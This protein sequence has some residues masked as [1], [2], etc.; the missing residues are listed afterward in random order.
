MAYN[1]KL[2]EVMGKTPYFANHRKY[3]N[4][5]QRTLLSLKAEA[6]IKS[7]EEMKKIHNNISNKL[8]H[9]QNQSISYI[10]KKRNTAP[11]LKKGDKVYLHTK[12]LRIK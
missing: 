3:S 12:N 9:A 10:N 5:F 1:N 8:I 11:Q 7:A 4:L 6:A 2:S